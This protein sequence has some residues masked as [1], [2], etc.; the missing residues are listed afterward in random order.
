MEIYILYSHTHQSFFFFHHWFWVVI[1]NSF[2]LRYKIVLSS[3][4]LVAFL[5]FGIFLGLKYET[6]FPGGSDGKHTTCN[7]GDLGSIPGS[8]RSPGE[9]RW[10]S[11]LVFFPGEFHGQRSLAGCSPWG[12]K[13]DSNSSNDY[14]NWIW[15]LPSP[16]CTKVWQPLCW[17]CLLIPSWDFCLS[18]VHFTTLSCLFP[19]PSHFIFKF[20]ILKYITLKSDQIRSVAQSCLTLC[21]PMNHSAPGLPVHHQLPEFTETHVHRVS[22]AIQPSHPL[23]GTVLWNYFIRVN[24]MRIYSLRNN[25]LI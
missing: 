12:R 6:A 22:D 9:G 18:G 23:S 15:E 24:I 17:S 21:D 7:A 3:S 16:D 19:F 10:A 14:E 13:D 20:F 1:Q 25:K 2:S 8:G 11:T 4:I 5:I